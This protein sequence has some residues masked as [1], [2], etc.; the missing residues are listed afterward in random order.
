MRL[1]SNLLLPILLILGIG[2]IY[3]C[4]S[5][6]PSNNSAPSCYFHQYANPIPLHPGLNRALCLDLSYMQ[7]ISQ[8][9]QSIAVFSSCESFGDG[10]NYIDRYAC[11]YSTEG[12]L[13][14]S[15]NCT[16][17]SII[18]ECIDENN[19]LPSGQAVLPIYMEATDFEKAQAPKCIAFIAVLWKQ[20]GVL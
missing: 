9:R 19:T 14:S 13:A 3:R 1:Y 8:P 6:C 2:L 11:H 17:S 7:P 15:N 20:T 5:I 10:D 12:M 16:K 18:V 4:R